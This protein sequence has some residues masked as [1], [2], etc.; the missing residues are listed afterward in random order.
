MYKDVSMLCLGVFVCMIVLVSP[1]NFI[2][3]N[4]VNC[5]D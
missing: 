4:I 2:Y 1:G 5:S 3:G